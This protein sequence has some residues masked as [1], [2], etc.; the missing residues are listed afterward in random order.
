VNKPAI[1]SQPA[2]IAWW[3]AAFLIAIGLTT[4]IPMSSVRWIVD[5]ALLI[6]ASVAGYRWWKRQGPHEPQD[7]NC[8]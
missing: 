3:P 1:I 4:F 7:P 5:I 2:R 8:V 6:A